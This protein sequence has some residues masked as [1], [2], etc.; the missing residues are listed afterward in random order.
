M[1]KEFIVNLVFLAGINLLIKPFYI[2]GIDL[3]MQNLVGWEAYGQY[4]ALFSFS[5]M[6][7]IF[8][9]LGIQQYNNKLVAQHTVLMEKYFPVILSMKVLLAGMFLVLSV[10][11]AIGAGYTWLHFELLSFLLLNQ[12][13]ITLTFFFRS[14][15]SGLQ[16]YRLD[17]LL[18]SLDKLLLVLF[19][20]PLV[21]PP[22]NE[23][24][25]IHYFVYAQTLAYGLTSI[26]AFVICRRYLTV[27]LRLRLDWLRFW[28]I[29]K[30]CSP[31]AITV[32]LMTAYTRMDSVMLERM[33]G[34]RGSFEAGIYASG[35]RLLDAVNI[36]G[37]LFASLLLPMF[38]RMLVTKQDAVGL[39]SLGQRIMLVVSVSFSVAVYFYATDIIALLYDKPTE[40]MVTV[41]Q[42]LMIGFNPIAIIHIA[43]TLL[44]AKGAMKTLN[45]LFF[46]G[47]LV[48]FI[49]NYFLIPEFGAVGAA[50]CTILTQSFVAIVQLFLVQRQFQIPRNIKMWVQVGLFVAGVI[51]LNKFLLDTAWV[52]WMPSFVL[53]GVL[54]V[55]LAFLSG[56]LSLR[57]IRSI[58]N[59]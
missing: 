39:W 12:I 10:L 46:A 24:V 44:T 53:A 38:A 8:T 19:C 37:Y 52:T 51:G 3:Q 18:S 36:I 47:V 13:F 49:G 28:V 27:P 2:F 26:V 9:D 54:S 55:V 7:Q 56:L 35:F 32:F 41:L 31:Y 6:F 23:G 57:Q 50:W 48:N 4:A 14:N 42:L 20:L 33:L 43:G 17:S 34:D 16:H 5:M 59:E 15:I 40:D 22:L 30:A 21:L 25:K 11:A 1:K 29:L 58:L 45:K